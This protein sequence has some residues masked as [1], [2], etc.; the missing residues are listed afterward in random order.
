MGNHI[1]TLGFKRLVADKWTHC[2]NAGI[3]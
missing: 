3:S 1:M 2:R